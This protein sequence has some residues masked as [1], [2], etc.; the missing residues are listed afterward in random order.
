MF[1]E[2]TLKHFSE[3]FERCSEVHDYELNNVTFGCWFSVIEDYDVI[4]AY[5]YIYIYICID[6]YKDI[7]FY[8]YIQYMQRTSGPFTY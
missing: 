3:V 2:F 8:I 4:A 7:L 5:L 6:S 1:S